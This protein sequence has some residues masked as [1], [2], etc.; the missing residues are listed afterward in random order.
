[1]QRV[2]VAEL[3][4]KLSEYLAH[5]KAGEELFVMEHGRTVARLVPAQGEDLD[6]D[7]MWL[8]ALERDGVIGPGG[9]EIPDSF[10]SLPR[11]QDPTGSVRAALMQ[12]RED[13]F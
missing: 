11:A 13:G 6:D 9:G 4:A 3:Q 5:V 8:D 10:F 12:D 1:M 7:L 2:G